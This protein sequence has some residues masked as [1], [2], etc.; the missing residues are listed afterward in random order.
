MRF[1][2]ENYRKAFPRED[3]PAKPVEQQPGSVIEEA[4]KQTKEP[5]GQPGSVIDHEEDP[6][7][8]E[9]DAKQEEGD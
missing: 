2:D 3:K 1:S 7:E 9:G 5:E 8:P 4:E 6:A